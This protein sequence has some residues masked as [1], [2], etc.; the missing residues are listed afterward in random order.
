MQVSRAAVRI[1]RGARGDRAGP[2]GTVPAAGGDVV[3]L[4]QLLALALSR[5]QEALVRARALLATRPPPVV[6]A[7]AAP[8]R[9]VVLRDFGDIDQALAE[10][11][12]A[13]RAAAR[14]GDARPGEPTSAPPTAWPWSWPGGRGGTG[15][16]RAAS[17]GDRGA[18]R[19][20]SALRQAHAL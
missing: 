4:E 17:E 20:A 8:G 19:D 2:A 7:V 14:A 18:R 12:A 15:A 13:L 5:P 9:G 1:Q 6:A 11:R 3:A 16:D 10:F